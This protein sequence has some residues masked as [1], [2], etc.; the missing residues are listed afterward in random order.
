VDA[1]C[2]AVAYSGGRDSTALLHATVRAA[3][4]QGLSVVALHVQHGLQP[5][6]EAW[7]RHCAATCRRWA[8]R[9]A[10]LRFAATRLDTAPAR[11]DSVEAWARRERRRALR[12][13]AL[14]HGATLLLLAQHRRD[15]AETVW[16]QALRGAGV[17]GLAAMPRLVERDGLCWA[18]PWLDMKRASIDAYLRRHRL[19]CIE[20]DSNADA[21]FAR[22]RLR[23]DV[24]PALSR[25]FPEAETALVAVA[26]HAQEAR[27]ALAELAAIDLEHVAGPDGLRLDD[28]ARLSPARRCNALRA[29]LAARI[30]APV[31]ATLVQRLMREAKAAG[32]ARWPLASGELRR[33]R[34]R[35]CFVPFETTPSPA[36]DAALLP[37]LDL[38]R[39]GLH[40]VPGWPGCVEVLEVGSRGIGRPRL[41]ALR[42]AAR[43]GGERL[44]LE[45]GRPPRSLK[46]QYQALD[47]PA[48]QRDGPLLY[49]DD[50]L[51]FVAGLGSDARAWARP[52][53]PQCALRWRPDVAM[54]GGVVSDAPSAP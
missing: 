46:K 45:P 3:A 34:G 28:W 14:A 49:A 26:R 22:N 35:L 43:R 15:Q 13:M 33:H 47:V 36:T 7:L 4:E 20:D 29:W 17:A 8:A 52:G 41:A 37:A 31:T 2:V 44:Q 5:Q 23:L 27:Q 30:G 32:A 10:P 40:R 24:W 50:Q 39:A 1:P 21:R 19:R 38:R 54:H 12:H 16:L 51:L 42:V 11:G 9:G 25:A 6:A 53:E 18:R 48:W